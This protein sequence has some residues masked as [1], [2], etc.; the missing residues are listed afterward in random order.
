MQLHAPSRPTNFDHISMQFYMS[1]DKLYS[2]DA[3]E[4]TCMTLTIYARD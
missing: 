2:Y 4:Y 3:S 1:L